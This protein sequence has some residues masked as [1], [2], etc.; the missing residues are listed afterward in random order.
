MKQTKR[1]MLNAVAGV[2]LL[3]GEADVAWAQTAPVEPPSSTGAANTTGDIVVTAQ[4]RV[5]R[6]Q[7]VPSAV[8]VLSA[9]ALEAKGASGLGDLAKEVSGLQLLG[10]ST[11]GTGKPTIRGISSG[12]DRVALVGI[13]LDDVPFTSESPR[14]TAE[15]PR[16]LAFDPAFADIERIEVLKG[17]QSTLYGASTVGGL[18]KYVSKEPDTTQLEGSA[19]VGATGIDGGGDGFNTRLSVNVPLSD[20]FAIRASAFYRADP[21]WVDE[22]SPSGSDKKNVN[23]TTTKGLRASLLLKSG[24]LK[25]VLTGLVQNIR[26]DGSSNVFLTGPSLGLLYGKP[27]Y[28]SPIDQYQ[29]YTYRSVSDTATLKLPFAT[30]TNV[31]AY[32]QVVSAQAEDFSVAINLL[33]PKTTNRATV[34]F[35]PTNNKRVSDEFRVAGTAGRFEW[36]VGLWYTRETFKSNNRFRGT[37]GTGAILPAAD[38]LYNVYNLDNTASINEW[39]AFGDATYHL[40]PKLEAT[41]GIRYS[42]DHQDFNAVGSGDVGDQVNSFP[43]KD[44]STDYLA[45]V[46]YKPSSTTSLYLRAASAYR[47]GGPNNFLPSSY[48]LG[49]PHSFGADK[50]WNYEAGAK[51]SLFDR[52]VSY[53]VSVYHMVWT[54]V[55]VNQL[56]VLAG[57]ATDSGIANAGKAKSDGA[58]LSISAHPSDTLSFG[59]NPSYNNARITVNAPGVGALA[60]NQL[61]YA[62]KFSSS[63]FVDYTPHLTSKIDGV[64][65][66][67]YNYRTRS[68]AG[69][70]Q[71]RNPYTIHAYGTLDLKAG[72]VWD[73]YRLDFTVDN[74][75]NSQ[76]VTFAAPVNYY[77]APLA[78]FTLRPRIYAMSIEVKF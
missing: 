13:Y 47:P 66:A 9:D 77:N 3:V 12:T 25:N 55:Q 74:V 31:A 78:G 32:N 39:A 50:L 57:G 22:V 52:R 49:A 70:E 36:L 20:N 15:A 26:S 45:T 73:R 64:I 69:F 23:N 11:A 53:E 28:A 60:G 40:T 58:E 7:D 30:I 35:L 54:N 37:D 19:R 59:V 76:A 71:S 1:A 75:T 24:D 4:K 5:Q 43:T 8:S 17:P 41:I 33:A 72:L 68:K 48:A 63:V 61:P 14:T 21:G 10:G 29:H 6:L 46:T 56:F 42:S 18:I 67:S 65:G 44:S 27:A 51:G 38:P 2:A 16:S 62:P 34:A